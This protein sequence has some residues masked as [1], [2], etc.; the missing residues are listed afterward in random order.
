MNN[1]QIYKFIIESK[2]IAP[3]T[4]YQLK[5]LIDWTDIIKNNSFGFK[6]V[7]GFQH[8]LEIAIK[9]YLQCERE[10]QHLIQNNLTN[11]N[12]LEYFSS[13]AIEEGI[14]LPEN[15]NNLMEEKHN[16]F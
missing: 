8:Q 7:A 3:L 14:S 6:E 16:E 4:Q 2:K 15:F 9:F 12:F 5:F 1:H 13:K 10:W 11:F